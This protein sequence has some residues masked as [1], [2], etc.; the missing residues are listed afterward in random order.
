MGLMICTSTS[1]LCQTG[2]RSEF[3]D[4]RAGLRHLYS[5]GKW[6][7]RLTTG[8]EPTNGYKWSMV[9]NKWFESECVHLEVK[10]GPILCIRYQWS[11]L[12]VSTSHLRT[13]LCDANLETWNKGTRPPNAASKAFHSSC[14][15]ACTA[16]PANEYQICPQHIRSSP[17]DSWVKGLA[18]AWC[19]LKPAFSGSTHQHLNNVCKWHQGIAYT[20]GQK[21]SCNG[22]ACN[23]ACTHLIS[24]R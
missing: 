21:K 6:K 2:V 14:P 24:L 23:N 4:Q 17:N 3:L 10:Y 7:D 15:A 22:T 9:L 5:G 1:S 16:Q 18:R 19:S 11:Q 20:F 13:N 8:H 12:G